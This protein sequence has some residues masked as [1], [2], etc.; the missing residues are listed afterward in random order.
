[1]PRTLLISGASS[2]IGR[3]IATG[4]AAEGHR[5][6]LG[7]RSPQ[8]LESTSLEPSAQVLLH[9]YEATQPASAE[10][11][12]TA[13]VGRFGSIDGLIH[14]AGVFS[15]AGLLFGA[16][17]AAEPE[18]IWTVNLMG[19]WWLTRSAWPWLV[20]SGRGRII[21]LVSMSGKRVRGGLAAYATSKFALMALC[22][23]MRQEGWDAGI[24][25]TAICPS[26]VN[27]EMAAGVQ[28][29]PRQEMT[30]PE[31]LAAQV[32]LLLALPASAVPF[33]LAISC[34]REW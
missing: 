3:A 14:C 16:E 9:T 1:M 5:L 13:T 8:A 29:I 27:T 7:V 33:E 34:Q 23:C 25:V 20:R 17:E 21:T 2:G 24:R 11:W 32:S 22:D 19:P 15:R 6:S 12:V 30:Q 28:A 4:L 26:W 10:D 18:R 31:D